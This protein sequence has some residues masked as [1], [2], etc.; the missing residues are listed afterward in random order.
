MTT[1]QSNPHA[2]AGHPVHAGHAALAG[3]VDQAAASRLGQLR[4]LPKNLII[5]LASVDFSRLVVDRRGIERLIPHRSAMVL[6]DGVVWHSADYTQGVAI[7][8]VRDD[9][10]WVPGHFPGRPLMPG[11]LQ[12]EASAQVSV[13]LYNARQ[14]EPQTAAFTRIEKCSFRATV[15]PG[16]ELFLICKEIKITRRGFV[17]HC[18]G[19][20]NGKLTFDAE[21]H[22]LTI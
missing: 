9:E 14:P 7:K 18:Q 5:D 8:H 1:T 17:S 4:D 6:V 3:H 13:L 12:I 2:P 15:V 19:L 22:G 21:I 16:D 20:A 11:V 10:F